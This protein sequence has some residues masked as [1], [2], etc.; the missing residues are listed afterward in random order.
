MFA[1]TFGLIYKK[2]DPKWSPSVDLLNEI[3]KV[4]PSPPHRKVVRLRGSGW[5]IVFGYISHKPRR[6][7]Y[8]SLQ[9]Y[10]LEWKLEAP[11]SHQNTFDLREQRMRVFSSWWSTPRIHCWSIFSYANNCNNFTIKMYHLWCLIYPVSIRDF[12]LRSTCYIGSWRSVQRFLLV[13]LVFR[14]IIYNL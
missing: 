10:C 3:Q 8:P 5:W 7:T 6:P 1:L 9:L 11:W 2:R 4:C 13:P 12:H 14:I